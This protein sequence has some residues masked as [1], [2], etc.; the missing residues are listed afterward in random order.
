MSYAPPK[1]VE[2]QPRVGLPFGLFSVVTFRESEDGHVFGGGVEWRA[3]DCGPVS[4]VE[5][6]GCTTFGVGEDLITKD[7]SSGSLKPGQAVPFL[8]YATDKC[9]ASSWAM[10]D[11]EANATAKLL[12]REEAQAE[13]AVWRRIAQ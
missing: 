6:P 9:G 12:A 4:A 10:Q 5:D 2:A 7:F 1:A 3:M 8:A 13:A 11:G